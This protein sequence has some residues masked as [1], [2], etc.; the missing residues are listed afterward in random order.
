MKQPANTAHL[1]DMLEHVAEELVRIGEIAA[2]ED[3]DEL[4][5]RIRAVWRAV[6]SADKRVHVLQ[7]HT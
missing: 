6:I 3:D 7:E 4:S 5:R 1:H 2:D